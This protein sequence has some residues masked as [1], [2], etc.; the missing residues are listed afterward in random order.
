[1]HPIEERLYDDPQQ[2]LRTRICPGCGRV[3]Y[4]P[5]YHCPRCGEE[6]A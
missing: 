2:E 5:G 6:S 3:L 4:A 1:M